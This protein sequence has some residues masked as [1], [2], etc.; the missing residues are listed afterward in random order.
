MGKG[1]SNEIFTDHDHSVNGKSLEILS[2][3]GSDSLTEPWKQ[4]GSDYPCTPGLLAI[5]DLHKLSQIALL[6]NPAGATPNAGSRQPDELLRV[7]EYEL[8]KLQQPHDTN[9]SEEK[10]QLALSVTR[11]F[12]GRIKTNFFGFQAVIS[13]SYSH[14][15]DF[16]DIHVNN[17]GDPFATGRSLNQSKF[18]ERAVLDYFAALWKAEWPH[19]VWTQKAAQSSEKKLVVAPENPSSYWGFVLSMGC[20]E[21]TL[22]GMWN[23]RDYLSGKIMLM[24]DHV[25]G[26]HRLEYSNG[27]GCHSNGHSNGHGKAGLHQEHVVLE[28]PFGTGLR[29]PSKESRTPICFYSTESHYSFRKAMVILRIKTFHKVATKLKF[30]PPKGFDSWPKEVPS[31]EDGSINVQ[32]LAVLVEEFAKRGYPALICF[33]YGTTF[34]GAYD[35]VGKAADLLFPIFRRHNLLNR[36]FVY[37]DEKG[38]LRRVERHGFWFHVDGALGAA[39][40]PFL[41][42]AQRHG[43]LEPEL[44]APIP[45]FDFSLRGK[46]TEDYDYSDIEVVNSIAVSGH[47]WIGCPFPTGVYMTKSKFQLMPPEKPNYIGTPDTTFSGSRSG[48]ASVLMWDYLSRHSFNDLMEKAVYS[49]KMASIL[50]GKLRALNELVARRELHPNLSPPSLWVS[51]SPLSLGVIFRRPNEA[52]MEK[53]ILCAEEEIV[54]GESRKLTHAYAMEHVTVEQIDRLIDDLCQDG[55]FDLEEKKCYRK[56]YQAD[57]VTQMVHLCS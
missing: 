23:G 53:Y 48:L 13:P 22:Y 17:V 30:P 12:Y 49:H 8:F 37:T 41:K 15:S 57:A 40:M 36:S 9:V 20:T 45:D 11:R 16:L 54:Q 42:M 2:N 51:H 7:C 52:I 50:A 6:K 39:H 35:N 25:D 46:N 18:M 29:S 33:N 55:A 31:N 10:R 4:P 24:D 26:E 27:N 56:S 19:D 43:M 32:S 34:K 1:M 5:D 44:D 3:R 38:E 47:K 21:G 14:L 28:N